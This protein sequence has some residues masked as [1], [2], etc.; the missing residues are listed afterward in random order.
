MGSPFFLRLRYPLG[1][2]C[3]ISHASLSCALASLTPGPG[4]SCGRRFRAAGA[5]VKRWT[6]PEQAGV[7]M[8]V[9]PALKRAVEIDGAATALVI[10]GGNQD[11][12][13]ADS[14]R[15]DALPHRQHRSPRRT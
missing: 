14:M 6:R 13:A 4:A 11:S 2:Q 12:R 7:W 10:G 3:V 9:E 8:V 1:L 15:I 5:S